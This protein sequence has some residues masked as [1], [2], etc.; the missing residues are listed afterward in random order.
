MLVKL[1]AVYTLVEQ[2]YTRTQRALATI[3]P[4]NQ[5]PTLL[6][7][8]LRKLSVLSERFNEMKQSS[9]RSGAVTALSRA[10]AW[11]PELDPV[12]ISTGRVSKLE[13]GWN[14]F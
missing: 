10:K 4:A 9:V 5:A 3:S 7:E 6:V 8:V 1:K 2:L 13:R 12:D 11:L 14:S